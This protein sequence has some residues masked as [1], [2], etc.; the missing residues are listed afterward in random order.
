MKRIAIIGSGSLG[1]QFQHWIENYSNDEFVGYFDDFS[2]HEKVLGKIDELFSQQDAFD[3]LL[4]AIGYNHLAFKH[5]LAQK[6]KAFEIPFYTFIHPTA[7]VDCTATIG[8]GSVVYPNATIDQRVTIGEHTVLNNGVI[9]SH[10][11]SIGDCSFLAPG[12]Q[13][14][15]NVSIG[16]C[17]FIGTGTILKNNLEIVPHTII[18][19]GSLVLQTIARPGTYFGHPIK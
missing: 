11:S 9:I 4:I 12:V 3:E 17:S 2:K 14:S 1:I 13:V 8:M 15:G 18:G 5:Q 6:I 16:H 19:A 7:Y 10:D